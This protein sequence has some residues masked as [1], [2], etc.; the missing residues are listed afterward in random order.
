MLLEKSIYK[1]RRKKDYAMLIGSS[2]AIMNIANHK[3]KRA[4][5]TPSTISKDL[6]TFMMQITMRFPTSQTAD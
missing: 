3:R 1:S 5:L 6:R 4:N 2:Y